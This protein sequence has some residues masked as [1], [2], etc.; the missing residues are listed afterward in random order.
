MFGFEKEMQK[1]KA[2]GYANKLDFVPLF[3]GNKDG[4]L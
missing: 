3:L 2:L 4:F 1:K